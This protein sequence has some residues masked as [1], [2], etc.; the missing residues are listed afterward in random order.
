MAARHLHHFG[1][2]PVVCYERR[3]DK[4]LY[5]ALVTQLE[6]LSI[7]FVSCAELEAAPLA[8]RRVAATFS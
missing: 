6:S 2:A 4:P 8:G 7:P 1:Y 5:N 3:T